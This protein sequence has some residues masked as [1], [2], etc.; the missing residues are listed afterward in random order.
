[1]RLLKAVHSMGEPES[2]TPEDLEKQRRSQDALGNMAASMSGLVWEP[3]TLAGMDAA[4]M[5]LSREHRRRR[6]ILYCHGGGYTSG[7]LGFSKVLASKLTRATGMDTLAFDYRLAPEHPYPAAVEDAL[8]AWGH[9]ES[10]GI[11]PGDIVLA[12]DSAG[13]NLALVLCLKLREAGRGLPGALLLMSP[14]TDMTASGE[15]LRGRA[16]IDPVLTPEYMYAVREAYA[17][18]LDPSDCLL[19]PL[20]ADFAG[21]PPALI[22]VGTHE[23]LYSDAERLAERMLEAGADCRLEVWENMWHDFQMYPSKTA[24]NAIQNMAHFLLEVL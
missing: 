10:L 15:S 11:A 9:L 24:S 6:V 21:F 16:G 5:R 22:Q 1:M 3:F 17:G 19:S 8:T 12:G 20:F 2:F 4:W 13:G 23:I 14:W 18:G 7:G